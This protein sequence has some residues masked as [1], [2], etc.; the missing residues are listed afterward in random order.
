MYDNKT[1]MYKFLSLVIIFLITTSVFSQK[2]TTQEYIEKWKNEAI[3]QMQVHKI[4]ASITLAQGILES[5]SGNSMLAVKGNNHFGIKCHNTWEGKKIYKDDDKKNECF[6]KYESA[7]ESFNDHADFLQK[8]RYDALFQLEI[9]DYRGWAKGLKKAGYATNPK[10]PTLLID[11]IERYELHKYD[12]P[13]DLI[14]KDE[15]DKENI[16]IEEEELKNE[17]VEVIVI[18]GKHQIK[19]T[20]NNVNYIVAK[21][22][23]SFSKIAKELEIMPWQLYKYNDWNKN[24]ELTKGER[25]YIKPKRAKAKEEYHIVKQGETMHSISQYH[26]IKLKKLYKKNLMTFGSQPRVGDKLHLRKKKKL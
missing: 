18:G 21:S 7:A 3:Y 1:I 9:T 5:G 16:I 24:H 6:R 10:Y 2:Q 19:T 20:G 11:L 15:D 23:D 14:V 26:A 25:V 12:L 17:N 22:G 4:P 13:T 8:K